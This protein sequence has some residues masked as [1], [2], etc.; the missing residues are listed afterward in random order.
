MAMIGPLPGCIV[1]FSHREATQMSA[2]LFRRIVAVTF[3]I[4]SIGWLME[5]IAE[6]DGT[7]LELLVGALL[8]ALGAG[9]LLCE[10][11]GRI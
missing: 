4:A 8:V 9:W 2:V 3:T 10:F 1:L 11:G 7:L 6:H 5:T